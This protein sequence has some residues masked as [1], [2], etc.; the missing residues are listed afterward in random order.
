VERDGGRT[1]SERLGARRRVLIAVAFGAVAWIGCAETTGPDEPF[2]LAFD[3]PAAPSIVSGDSLRDIE[4]NA[5]ALRAVAYNLDGRALPDA[6]VSY[7][8]IDTSGALVVDQTTGH[9]VASGT[10]RGTARIVAAAGSL[11]SAP[12]TIEIVPPPARAAQSGAIDTLKYSFSALNTS[13]PLRVIVTRD[14]ANAPVPRYLVRFRLERLADTVI[15]RLIDDAA[16]RSPLDPTGATSIDTTGTDGIA[17]RQIRLT[18]NASLNAA[19]DS[20]IVLADVRL[21]GAPVTGSPVRLRLLVKLRT[22]P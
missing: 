22:T 13:G 20:V 6:A 2:S 9:L 11:Q 19:L 14:S 8:V 1:M 17:S 3:P 15:A 5:I 7:I 18:P 10:K 4:G 16:R 12:I 21:R